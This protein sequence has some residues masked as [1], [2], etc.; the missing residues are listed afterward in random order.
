M[1]RNKHKL[2]E[3]KDLFNKKN[4]EYSQNNIP[5]YNEKNDKVYRLFVYGKDIFKIKKLNNS[6]PFLDDDCSKN[7]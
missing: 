7:I 4:I 6:L 2:N 3:F 1:T 5:H